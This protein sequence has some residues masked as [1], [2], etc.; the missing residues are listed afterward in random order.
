[1]RQKFTKSIRTLIIGLVTVLLIA[2]PV[3]TAFAESSTE[4]G[5]GTGV[6]DAQGSGLAGV[7]GRGKITLSGSGVLWFNDR[8]GDAVI[9]V[10][11]D[12]NMTKFPGGWTLY[13]GFNGRAYVTG[14]A[15]EVMIVGVR[16]D[17]HAEGT[18][19]FYLRG[20][21]T[22]TTNHSRGEWTD[23]LKMYRLE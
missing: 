18:G 2:F 14:S 22:Y 11:G 16:I 21:G 20:R 8:A 6:L 5:G 15:V 4:G 9:H 19:R 1:M 17:L 10:R 13:T 23:T 7:I 12:G 3:N